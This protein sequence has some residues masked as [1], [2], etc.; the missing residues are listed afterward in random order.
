M[1]VAAL[2]CSAPPL[3]SR[4]RDV[5]NSEAGGAEGRRGGEI[6]REAAV[7]AKAP[8]PIARRRECCCFRS[9]TY[10]EEQLLNKQSDGESSPIKERQQKP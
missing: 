8:S 3:A 10:G 5:G 4:R 9:H 2:S 1:A 7:R 6:R